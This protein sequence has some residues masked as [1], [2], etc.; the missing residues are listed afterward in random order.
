MSE[1]IRNQTIGGYGRPALRRRRPTA[2]LGILLAA[3]VVAGAVLGWQAADGSTGGRSS[4][5]GSIT[6]LDRAAH[7]FLIA[8]SVHPQGS[9]GCKTRTHAGSPT[10]SC[11]TGP[12]SLLAVTI[13]VVPSTRFERC[14]NTGCSSAAFTKLS[15]GQHVTV[16]GSRDS[17]AIVARLVSIRRR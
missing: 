5:T 15:A 3:V 7:T 1:P 11:P 17:T 4:V 8:P 9:A 10:V 14:R 6:S 12:A 2:V 16:V 13:R